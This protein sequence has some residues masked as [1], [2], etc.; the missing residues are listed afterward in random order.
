MGLIAMLSWLGKA[1]RKLE[2]ASTRPRPPR[3]KK[4][5]QAE[6]AS[7]ADL[8]LALGWA[9]TWCDKPEVKIGP[10]LPLLKSG[11]A[12]PKHFRRHQYGDVLHMAIRLLRLEASRNRSER[13]ASALPWVVFQTGPQE[14]PCL[15]AR[16]M[17]GKCVEASKGF[18]IPL[19]DCN[20]PVCKCHFRAITAREKKQR[21]IDTFEGEVLGDWLKKL[22]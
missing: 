7:D 9:A 1:A 2:G 17:N 21:K 19:A 15:S 5:E 18:Q 6:E 12:D 22:M 16:N 4:I 10:L 20:Q 8:K 14:C 13:A 3:L 11:F